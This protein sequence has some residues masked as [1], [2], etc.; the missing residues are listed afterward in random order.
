MVFLN[1]KPETVVETHVNFQQI[2]DLLKSNQGSADVLADL[3]SLP[4]WLEAKINIENIHV[5][6]DTI[7]RDGKPLHSLLATRI[8]EMMQNGWD[9]EP[10]VKFMVKLYQNPSQTAIDELF[11]W[12][13]QAKMPIT[14]EG[15]FLAYKKVDGNYNSYH[16][17]PEGLVVS[18]KIGETVEMDRTTVDPDRHRTC[19]AGLHFCSFSYLPHYHGS[20]G[21]V[22]ILEINPADVVAIPSD[23]NNAKGR[24]WKYTVVG[25]VDQADAADAFHGSPVSDGIFYEEDEEDY[26]MEEDLW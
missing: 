1:G 13:D 14:P 18:N 20:K 24:A 3:I 22:V 8:I 11:L 5:T 23:Y 15:N 9:V 7:Y 12:L 6:D 4:K 16:R 26:D 17:G 19:S 21:R 10:W 2:S 25:E